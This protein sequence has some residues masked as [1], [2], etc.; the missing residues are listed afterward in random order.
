MN[1]RSSAELT[2]CTFDSNSAVSS[3]G[4]LYYGASASEYVAVTSCQFVNNEAVAADGGAVW[5]VQVCG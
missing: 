3:G 4:A 5:V 1:I 2:N